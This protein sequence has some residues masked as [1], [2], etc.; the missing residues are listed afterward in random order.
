MGQAMCQAY[1]SADRTMDRAS[2]GLGQDVRRMCWETTAETLSETA[3]AQPAIL[4]VSLACLE[5]LLEAGVRPAAVAGLSLGEYTALVA[6]GSLEL[7]ETMRLVRRRAELMQRAVPKGEGT[8]TALIGLTREEVMRACAV[9]SSQ[10]VVEP[11]NFNAP[12]QI[13]ISGQ[14]RAVEAAAEAAR[15][16][17][18]RKVVPLAVSAPFHCSLLR[19]VAGEFGQALAGV[20]LRAPH[21]A[22]VANVSARPVWEP[23]QIRGSLLSQISSPVLWEESVLYMSQELGI[24]VFVEIGPGHVLSRFINRIAPEATTM[25]YDG[26]ETFRACLAELERLGLTLGRGQPAR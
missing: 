23:A 2:A 15:Q 3:N 11:A 8:M 16:A 12:D 19:N 1:E 21:T 26:P 5:P 10:G 13:V 22:V 17:G 14:T 20:S 25:G 6:A 18:A 9:G 4:A 7:G 24:E